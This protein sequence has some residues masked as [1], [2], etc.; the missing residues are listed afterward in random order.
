MTLRELIGECNKLHCG[1]SIM[2]YDL[3]I[4]FYNEEGTGVSATLATKAGTDGCGSI[5]LDTQNKLTLLN[6]VEKPI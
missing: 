1:D 3:A 4:I 5:Y 2:D 6:C